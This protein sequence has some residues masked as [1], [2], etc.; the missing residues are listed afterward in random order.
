MATPFTI[1]LKDIVSK[2]RSFF[3]ANGVGNAAG[4]V[5]N[6]LK[7]YLQPVIE[8]NKAF[9]SVDVRWSPDNWAPAML[10]TDVII[11]VVPDVHKSK[12]A[13]N[14][15]TAAIAVANPNI[16]GL[17]D[18][19][20]K[21]CEVYFDRMFQGSAKELAGAAYH[22]AAHI[23]SNMDDSLHRGQD[24]FLRSGPDYNGSPSAKNTVFMAT[25]LGRK[26]SMRS[27]L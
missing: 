6:L 16:L 13:A 26:V 27:G 5:V 10:D 2:D 4:K 9:S 12:I 15:G 19:N 1:H 23:K 11:Y 8:K 24:A 7:S 21:I 22:E 25:H 18:L 20:S 3:A 14:G 17:T